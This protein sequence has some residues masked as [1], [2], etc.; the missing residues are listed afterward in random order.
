MRRALFL[1]LAIFALG[2]AFAPSGVQAEEAVVTLTKGNFDEVVKANPFIVVEF[3]A[4]WCG[5]CKRLAPEYEKAAQTLAKLET[6]KVTLAKV[7]ATQESDLASKF[8]VRGY[9]TLKIFREGNT[10]APAEYEGPRDADGIVGYLK[11]LAGPAL[12]KHASKKD[13]EAAIKDLDV[14]VVAALAPGSEALSTV[15]VIANQMRADMEFHTVEAAKDMPG[16]VCKADGTVCKSAP[17][18]AVVKKYDEP[19]A[20]YGGDVTDAA[21]LTAWIQKT[22]Q[23]SIIMLSRDSKYRRHL[24]AAFSTQSKKLLALDKAG[25]WKANG[26]VVAALKAVQE[27][28]AD[29]IAG[30]ELHVLGVDTDENNAA[31]E[32]F[33]IGSADLP[34]LVIH[35]V[36]RDAK[37]VDRK[38]NLGKAAEWVDD[39]LSGRVNRFV[40]SEEPPTDNSGPVKVL[41]AKQFDEIVFD[42]GKAVLVEFYAPWCGHC[43][44]LA[45]VYEEVGKHFADNDSVVVAK[46]DAT[47]NDV[48][49]DKFEVKGFPT[50][51]LYVPQMGDAIEYKGDRSEEDLIKFVELNSKAAADAA[52]KAGRE[53]L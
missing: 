24:E 22:T 41:V 48:P 6:P 1:I 47:A 10:D 29:E 17:A 49:S 34:A 30:G 9:P 37:Y 38:A 27:Q 4:P 18:V 3:Y 21:E 7:D 5:H 36:K 35:D 50:I 15:E 16:A 20:A 53:D 52:A 13:L 8:G 12:T 45:P 46:M 44:K 39:V 23:P 32:Y 31:M 42:S 2:A 28:F 33:G 14:A 26:P 51:Y 40:K 25:G 19:V 43:K 11:K